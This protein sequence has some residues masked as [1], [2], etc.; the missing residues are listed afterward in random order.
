MFGGIGM[1]IYGIRARKNRPKAMSMSLYFMRLRV[2]AQGI[3]V[4]ALVLG[5]TY[6][7]YRT[8]ESREEREANKDLTTMEK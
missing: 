1:V 2:L 7:Y 5:A 8:V 4:S 6:E 3:V